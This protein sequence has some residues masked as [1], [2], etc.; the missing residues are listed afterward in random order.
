M[1]PTVA[2]GVRP[3]AT[4]AQVPT[5]HLYGLSLSPALGLCPGLLRANLVLAPGPGPSGSLGNEGEKSQVLLGSRHTGCDRKVKSFH[6]EG[7]FLGS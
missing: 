3:K 5:P 4:P 1:R 2:Q 7:T 6:G